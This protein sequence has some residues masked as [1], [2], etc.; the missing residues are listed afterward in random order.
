MEL[1]LG[2]IGYPVKHS[3]SPW[4]HNRLMERAT[5]AGDYSVIEIGPN[6]SFEEKLEHMKDSGMTGFNITVPYKKKIIPYLNQLDNNARL[7]GAVNTVVNKNG[8][9]I[10]YNTD[11]TGYVTGLKNNYPNLFGDATRILL[12]GAGGAARGIYHGLISEGFK[13]IDLANRTTSSAE[14][15]AELR[16]SDTKTSI[17]TLKDA[18]ETINDYDLIIQTTSVGMKPEAEKRIISAASVNP[19]SV[20]S[21]I[22]YQPI[23]TRFLADA[24][25][26]GASIHYGHTM[27]LYQAQY[28]FEL[29]TGK[30]T[31]VDNMESQLK[32]VLEGR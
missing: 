22:V 12:I 23:E 32:T 19:N 3:L 15:I 17:L 7:I 9:W 10:G 20:V 30:K 16:N 1:K 4:I 11:G 13:C 8:E 25:K 26:A 14:K 27:L 28:A 21:D 29:W 2:L 6:D 18:E 31:P 5:I 24:K